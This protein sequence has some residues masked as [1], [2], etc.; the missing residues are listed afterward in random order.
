M[1]LFFDALFKLY[2][3]VA[4]PVLLDEIDELEREFLGWAGTDTTL[5]R[6]GGVQFNVEGKE[7]GHVHSSG[8]LDMLFTREIK[9][10]LLKEGR[11]SDHHI[12]KKSGWISF[13][14]RGVE[15]KAYALELLHMAYLR[16][17]L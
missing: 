1:A 10:Q 12:F 9:Q 6:F 11:V 7:L 8:L 5:H 3:A 15:D 13:Y 2:N 17:M 14:I 16:R 4:R